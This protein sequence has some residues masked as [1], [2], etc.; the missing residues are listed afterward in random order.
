MAT[1]QINI[2]QF[3][4]WLSPDT[5]LGNEGTF[6]Y[7][8]NID[9]RT[10]PRWIQLNSEFSQIWDDL[11]WW[12]TV[13]GVI[14]ISQYSQWWYLTVFTLNKIFVYRG[15]WVEVYSTSNTI[16][17][18]DIFR[19]SG[20]DYLIIITGTQIKKI[21]L[22]DAVDPSKIIPWWWTNYITNTW[23]PYAD[24]TSYNFAVTRKLQ[25]ANLLIWCVDK[26]IK[27]DQTWTTT[28][29]YTFGTYEICTWITIVGDQLRVYTK[30]WRDPGDW[31]LYMCNSSAVSSSS[32]IFDMVI[33]WEQMPVQSVKSIG[34]ID[35]AVIWDTS[36]NMCNL[37]IAQWYTKEKVFK[38]SNYNNAIFVTEWVNTITNYN[39]LL[40]LLGK[41]QKWEYGIFSYGKHLPWFPDAMVF[42]KVIDDIS[43]INNMFSVYPFRDR[44]YVSY[45]SSNGHTKIK[46]IKRDLI[47]TY[48]QSW[49]MVTKTVT[50]WA[51]WQRKYIKEINVWYD[52]STDNNHWWSIKI[53]CRTNNSWDISQWWEQIG[54]D[55]VDDTVNYRRF[56][57]NEVPFKEWNMLQLK[58][59]LIKWNNKTPVLYDIN[60][61]YDI[62]NS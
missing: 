47:D 4:N 62:V 46:Y 54:T 7:S 13:T 48:S 58:V 28:V 59:E 42:D 33:P 55:I 6:Q 14:D 38:N 51:V 52:I 49:E 25:S 24:I 60:I 18:S 35:Y 56:L 45:I 17:W 44:L 61:T 12:Y 50:W 41:N 1:T 40:V 36:N 37:V 31:Y 10:N 3:Y 34:N 26:I 27:L 5:I 2:S 29:I 23:S 22:N 32:L 53:Y 57:P 21:L 15:W 43:S 11:P 9:I 39:D 16:I 20:N 30:K 8:K 19:I